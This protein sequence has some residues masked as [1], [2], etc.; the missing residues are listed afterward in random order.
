MG[1]FNKT[2][3]GI[4]AMALAVSGLMGT[5]AY[6]ET[7]E[8][9]GTAVTTSATTDA[10]Q[11][12]YFTIAAKWVGT[13]IRL[14]WNKVPNATAYRVSIKD[15]SVEDSKWESYKTVHGIGC[16]LTDLE[17]NHT[18]RICIMAVK[19]DGES[20]KTV[21]S[22]IITV[23]RDKTIE[24]AVDGITIAPTPST[25][26]KTN[27][28]STKTDN[29]KQ[30]EKNEDKTAGTKDDKTDVKQDEKTDEKPTVNNNYRYGS[31]S[32][33]VACDVNYI[34]TYTKGEDAL[35]E[36]KDEHDVFEDPIYI[37]GNMKLVD[38]GERNGLSANDNFAVKNFL[39][40]GYEGNTL[41]F[42]AVKRA[43][44]EK[45][46]TFVELSSTDSEYKAF[47]S[48]VESR[49][50]AANI[51]YAYKGTYKGL[52]VVFCKDA[53]GYVRLEYSGTGTAKTY[54]AATGTFQMSQ[55]VDVYGVSQNVL[56]P[57]TA[58]C[59]ATYDMYSTTA[60]IDRYISGTF[61]VTAE[62]AKAYFESLEKIGYMPTTVVDT[63]QTSFGTT[64]YNTGK[65]TI[66]A[67]YYGQGDK[68]GYLVITAA[69]KH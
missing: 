28:D 25:D 19:E 31:G 32:T 61:A 30:D 65:M 39:K 18:Y 20:Y 56:M 55:V 69:H 40:L 53:S 47:A 58:P 63:E 17:E 64:F 49:G 9:A 29:T 67:Q 14:M 54:P 4:C 8:S 6:A 12:T 44:T 46:V 43:L 34:T 37:A 57:T 13:N 3:V 23:L 42:D 26:D 60:S 21:T 11:S 51:D 35:V 27:T 59:L 5:V 15:T 48:E 62:Q 24:G 45:G 38:I 22:R 1:K 2:V 36:Y 52:S 10:V 16:Y 50:G 41:E 33:Y 68:S 66:Y 7:N